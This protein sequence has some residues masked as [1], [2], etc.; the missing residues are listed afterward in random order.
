MQDNQKCS[1]KQLGSLIPDTVGLAGCAIQDKTQD[2]LTEEGS[3][4][5]SLRGEANL[6]DREPM[7]SML[8]HVLFSGYQVALLATVATA[9]DITSFHKNV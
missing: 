6:R 2:N 3:Q 5:S 1:K 8:S 4:L 9:Y 7:N